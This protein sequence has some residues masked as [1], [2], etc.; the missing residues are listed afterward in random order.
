PMVANYQTAPINPS[1]L[2]D[3]RNWPSATDVVPVSR[4]VT[5][6]D[7]QL[8]RQAG[9]RVDLLSRDF[10][11]KTGARHAAPPEA[12]AAILSSGTLN[13]NRGQVRAVIASPLAAACAAAEPVRIVMP[14][15]CKIGHA[16]KLMFNQRPTAAEEVSLRHLAHVARS[17]STL[18][19]PGVRFTMV[20]DAHGCGTR[21]PPWRRT[22]TPCGNCATRSLPKGKSN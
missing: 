19:R 2:S 9:E 18:Y 3:P 13:F 21:P 15:F 7:R 10:L 5:D 20:T 16:A 8:V 1:Y 22:T 14:A 12:L 4:P 11:K 17:L 6:A